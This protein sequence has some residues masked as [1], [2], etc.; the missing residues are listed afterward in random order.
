MN[1]DR[2]YERNRLSKRKIKERRRKRDFS[3]ETHQ[4]DY[5][6]ED[7]LS[8]VGN[9][10]IASL[11][12]SGLVQAK[13][14]ISQP[15]DIYEQEADRIAKN[16]INTRTPNPPEVNRVHGKSNTKNR[17]VN[18]NTESKIKRLKGKGN[19]LNKSIRE[20]FEPRFG[21]DLGN[22]KVHTD[23]EAN[24]LAS[25]IQAKAFTYGNDIVFGEGQYQLGTTEGKKLIAHEL[26]HTMQQSE[27]LSLDI[28]QR[29]G[30]FPLFSDISRNDIQ[31]NL[32]EYYE[33]DDISEEVIFA[34]DIRLSSSSLTIKELKKF[35]KGMAIKFQY[36]LDLLGKIPQVKRLEEEKSDYLE[37]K[38]KIKKIEMKFNNILSE[39][40]EWSKVEKQVARG[41]KHFVIDKFDNSLIVLA[42][43]ILFSQNEKELIDNLIK[44][45]E[46]GSEKLVKKAIEKILKKAFK[47][48]EGVPIFLVI[49]GV[50]Y[51]TDTVITTLDKY[52]FPGEML[53]SE[54]K[55]INKSIQSYENLQK[56]FPTD[57]YEYCRQ[58]LLFLRTMYRDDHVYKYIAYSD[59]EINVLNRD[60]EYL[61]DP[62]RSMKKYGRIISTDMIYNTNHPLIRLFD[63]D[64]DEEKGYNKIGKKLN[65][66]EDFFP[67]H[68]KMEYYSTRIYNKGL[69][70]NDDICRYRNESVDNFYKKAR[71]R[72]NLILKPGKNNN[73]NFIKWYDSSHP[74]NKP[75]NESKLNKCEGDIVD[76][77]KWFEKTFK[78]KIEKLIWDGTTLDTNKPKG[79]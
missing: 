10:E 31:S 18:S 28:V 48:L 43:K 63:K 24:Q 45:I 73:F 50:S 59:Y 69:T 47:S 30:T 55:K 77:N 1:N 53:I 57:D 6:F 49:D 66:I 38:Q 79:Y 71:E 60:S 37:N 26:A 27:G 11:L 62:Y 8:D 54:Y 34:E 74:N 3:Y 19:P 58:A 21:V 68:S 52:Y 56:Y 51:L 42:I 61:N 78:T 40:A 20:Y 72:I 41:I 16:I 17:S 14:N 9:L 65:P 25:Y 32:K 15:G 64:T 7:L 75:D 70:I 22:V 23:S 2:F 5:S 33:R 67:N 13:L 12:E 46:K 44:V 36:D 35:C 76:Y 29:D 39:F 4:R